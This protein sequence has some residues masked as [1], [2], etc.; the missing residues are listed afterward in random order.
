MPLDVISSLISLLAA[1]AACCAAYFS[2]KVPMTLR[3]EK[4]KEIIYARRL[5]VLLMTPPR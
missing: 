4:F 3:K 2:W 5:A 1:A